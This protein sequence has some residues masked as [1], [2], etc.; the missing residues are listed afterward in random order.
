MYT[1]AGLQAAAIVKADDTVA[2]DTAVIAQ[3]T[4]H[5]CHSLCFS[6]AQLNTHN[7]HVVTG[8]C[9]WSEA[10]VGAEQRAME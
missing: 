3:V 6:R 1:I 2:A 8:D 9:S 4:E 5:G 7:V 10:E